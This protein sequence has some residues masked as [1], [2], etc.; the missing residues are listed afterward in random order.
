MPLGQNQQT[1]A[2]LPDAEVV[3]VPGAGHRPW[4]ERPGCVASALATIRGR[5]GI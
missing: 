3:G 5:A 4:H 2:L 1:A